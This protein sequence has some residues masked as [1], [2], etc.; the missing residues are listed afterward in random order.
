[1]KNFFTVICTG[2]LFMFGASFFLF[3]CDKKED[4]TITSKSNS[5]SSIFQRN[6]VASFEIV[7]KEGTDVVV[8]DLVFP[9]AAP[10]PICQVTIIFGPD[11]PL[12]AEDEARGSIMRTEDD[13]I[14]ITYQK[15]AMP[16]E[17]NGFFNDGILTMPASKTLPLEVTNELGFE[18]AYI[19]AKGE[20]TYTEDENYFYVIF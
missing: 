10:G 8:D 3:S 5:N 20:Y 19:I 12:L 6:S 14:Q 11:F 9:C 4:N 13:K 7:I 16:Q 2:V 17:M 15:E 18:T 1:M